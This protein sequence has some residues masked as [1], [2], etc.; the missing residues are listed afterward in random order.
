MILLYNYPSYVSQKIVM[1]LKVM[2]SS[3]PSSTYYLHQKHS[4]A[5]NIWFEWKCAISDILRRHVATA[6]NYHLYKFFEIVN[7]Y[8]YSSRTYYVPTTL[9]VFTSFASLLKILANPKSE[10]FGFMSLSNKIL[11]VFRSLWTICSLES[12]WR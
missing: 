5:I 3:I 7:R 2:E 11:L 10:I 4:K 8:V 12:W 6:S 1:V 9:F